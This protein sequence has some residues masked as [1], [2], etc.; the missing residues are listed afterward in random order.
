M[1]SSKDF[2]PTGFNSEVKEEKSILTLKMV[3]L[4]VKSSNHVWI[5]TA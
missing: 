2:S 4:Q 3:K 1:D 5:L